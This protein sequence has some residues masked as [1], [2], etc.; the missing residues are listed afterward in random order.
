MSPDFSLLVP[1]GTK[2]QGAMPTNRHG[3]LLIDPLAQ[4]IGITSSFQNP[5]PGIV[6]FGSCLDLHSLRI[7]TAGRKKQD[8]GNNHE[9][10]PGPQLPGH[11][12]QKD[13]I[14]CI[15]S[16]FLGQDKPGLPRLHQDLLNW[17]E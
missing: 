11:I 16:S 15:F 6:E 5:D 10:L 3:T 8:Q 1:D 4:S 14:H 9:Q 2:N 13:D 17:L 12:I 7:G